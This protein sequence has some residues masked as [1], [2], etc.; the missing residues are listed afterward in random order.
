VYRDLRVGGV[1]LSAIGEVT[2]VSTSPTMAVVRVNQA[3]DAVHSGDL[4]VPRR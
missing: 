2:V 1:P 3:R 4:L